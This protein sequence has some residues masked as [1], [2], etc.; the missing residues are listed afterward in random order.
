MS[1]GPTILGAPSAPTIHG[2]A[3]LVGRRAV[4]LRGASGSGKSTLALN[5]LAEAE[6]RGMLARL[7]GDDRLHVD[8][9]HGRVIVRA[10]ASLHG[11]LEVRGRGILT[12]PYEAAGIVALVVD[13]AAEP[14]PRMPEHDQGVTSLAGA[15]LPYF[16][17]GSCGASAARRV[18]M[19]LSVAD[20]GQAPGSQQ[21]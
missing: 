13:I 7:I 15:L 19:V 2:T 12:L 10:V 4:V 8:A 21:P 17:P 11:L 9:C 3:V 20:G 18:L 16:R 6:A 1:A 5:L 14:G